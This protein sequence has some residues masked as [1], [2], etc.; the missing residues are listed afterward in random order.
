[1][2]CIG[3]D[4]ETS[5]FLL[6]AIEMMKDAAKTSYNWSRREWWKERVDGQ[7]DI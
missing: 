2:E 4:E 7:K 3:W 1:M 5:Q 6:D